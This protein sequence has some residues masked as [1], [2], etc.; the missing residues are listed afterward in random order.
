M[1]A[2][3]CYA[4]SIV[5]AAV[6]IG[7]CATVSTEVVPLVPELKFPPTENVEIL[8]EK[9]KRPYIPIALLE[10]RG[11]VGDT[12]AELWQHAREKAR[13]LGADALIRLEVDKTV[14]PP[15]VLY[16]PFFTPF[17]SPFYSPFYPRPY[18]YAYP[19]PEYRVIPGGVEYTLKTLAIKYDGAKTGNQD[20][21]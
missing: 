20:G 6:F 2:L 11:M 17:Y 3:R 19:F 12:E 18:F 7:G 15:V 5:A 13:E 16:D 4:A 10:T 21:N 1:P 9:P 8:L 14:R